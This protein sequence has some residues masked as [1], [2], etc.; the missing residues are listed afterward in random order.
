MNPDRIPV[1]KKSKIE[2]QAAPIPAKGKVRLEIYGEEIV[3]KTVR[4]S[5]NSGRVY[6]PMVW[7]GHRVKIVRLNS[8]AS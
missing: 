5:G 7:V 2:N 6:L 4:M 8:R 1:Q 3:E